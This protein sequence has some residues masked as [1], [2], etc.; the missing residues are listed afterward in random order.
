MKSGRLGVIS[1]YI[2]LFLFILSSS[3]AQMAFEAKLT[4]GQEVPPVT[5]NASGT[6]T[7]NLTAEGLE[8]LITFSNMSMT[9]AHIH[10]GRIGENGDVVKTLTA[11]FEGNTASGIWTSTDSEPLNETMIEALLKGELY[12]NIH[13]EDHPDGEIRGQIEN[14]ASTSFTAVLEGAQLVPA[15]ETDAKGTATFNLTS[16]G[17]KYS[18]TVAGSNVNDAEIYIG[19]RDEN[20][21]HVKTI[22][23]EGNTAVGVWTKTEAE[24]LTDSI[25]TEMLKGNLYVEVNTDIN[26]DG[27]L[28]GQVELDGGINLSAALSGEQVEPAVESEASGTAN[29]TLTSAG[30]VYE[31]AFDSININSA[32]FFRG[33][34]G[35]NG[36]M[37]KDIS[38]SVEGNTVVG[39]WLTTD[40]TGQLTAEIMADIIE[41][42]VYLQI[43]SDMNPDGELRGQL[44]FNS[45]ASLNV[46]LINS[47]ETDAQV[48]GVGTL[49]LSDTGLD[50][51]FTVP[52]STA[53][54]IKFVTMSENDTAEVL[55]VIDTSAKVHANTFAG[56][57]AYTDTN[58]FSE[59]YLDAM[60][61]GEA[62]IEVEDTS[63]SGET[64]GYIKANADV[65]LHANLY[66][67]QVT[68]DITSSANATASIKIVGNKAVY[69][70][71]VDS[72]DITAA[73]FHQ[74]DIGDDGGPVKTI[75]DD[76]ENNTAIGVW[77]STDSEPLDDVMTEALM[78]G[79]LYLNIH[80]AENPGG[81]IR[82]Q[83]LVKGGLAFYSETS[84]EYLLSPVET[85]AHGTGSFIL[86]SKGLIYNY[87]AENI[88][89]IDLDLHYGAQ[90]ETGPLAF[91]LTGDLTANT[92]V[93]VWLRNMAEGFSAEDMSNLL[94][95][96]TYLNITS[97]LYTDGE[98]RGQVRPFESDGSIVAVENDNEIELP[99]NIV[100]KQNYPNP[101]NPVTTIEFF[102]PEK[103]NVTLEIYNIIGQRVTTLLNNELASG[104]HKVK[105]DGANLASGIYVYSLRADNKVISK[106][107]QLI[108]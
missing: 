42:S 48:I 59:A 67:E 70:I 22:Q 12:V 39:A 75:T 24:P 33:E 5:T 46:K 66:A 53:N 68:S 50:Y 2:F 11:D 29:F 103:S 96:E 47:A 25:I 86:T 101:F 10:M 87:S 16:E 26:P 58:A 79:N 97:A 34:A 69:F 81:E 91:A 73:H 4:G 43:G 35:S 13:S 14:S 44:E 8:Y 108:K 30:L 49:K 54:E 76:F 7:F 102:I 3:F 28:R 18:I 85:E 9:N 95:G 100:L 17:L 19:S 6:A 45:N 107:M 89:I 63:R 27:E 77:S 38:T 78:K 90:G 51:R 80:T 61:K 71:T 32:A 88:S 52:G 37:L 1:I 104:Y 21:E 74:G 62:W 20:G 41:G 55:A 94:R 40:N 23:F 72:I 15:I 99:K 106:K 83:V 84:G 31:A 93:G 82:G 56:I 98:M 105:F 60:L 65:S 92:A 36:E 57:W 64:R